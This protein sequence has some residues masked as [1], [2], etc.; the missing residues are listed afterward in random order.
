MSKVNHDPLFVDYEAEQ[1]GHL[2]VPTRLL[3][4]YVKKRFVF[5]HLMRRL[6]SHLIFMLAFFYYIYRGVDITE[7]YLA[8][9]GLREMILKLGATVNHSSVP[10]YYGRFEDTPRAALPLTFEGIHSKEAFWD[11]VTL[12][13]IPRLYVQS[14]PDYFESQTRNATSPTGT[15]PIHYR[16]L[17]ADYTL[18]WGVRF[19]QHWVDRPSN[20]NDCR[21]VKQPSDKLYHSEGGWLNEV[22][23]GKWRG[24]HATT[25][26]PGRLSSTLLAKQTFYEAGHEERHGD[27]YGA[28]SEGFDA[29][30]WII[31][32]PLDTK[33]AIALVTAMKDGEWIGSQTRSMFITFHAIHPASGKVIYTQLF[34]EATPG[35]SF[36]PNAIFRAS[37][38]FR[39]SEVLVYVAGII[40][41]LL[42]VDQVLHL[43]HELNRAELSNRIFQFLD[44]VTFGVSYYLF[45]DFW[46]IL[47][48]GFYERYMVTVLQQRDDYV[49]LYK[50]IQD[51]R[52][53]QEWFMALNMLGF[54]RAAR[55]LQLSDDIHLVWAT[56]KQS[57]SQVT[58]ILF[59]AIPTIIGFASSAYL[60]F[61]SFNVEFNTFP[62]AMM[63]LVRML[64]GDDEI[65]S[66]YFELASNAPQLTPFFFLCVL[67]M[68]YF[69][70]LSLLQGL[71]FSSWTMT[72]R[73]TH[74]RRSNRLLQMREHMPTHLGAPWKQILLWPFREMLYLFTRKSA[75]LSDY[76][77]MLD[78]MNLV[79]QKQKRDK[80]EFSTL[81]EVTEALITFQEQEAEKSK[82][83]NKE[84]A[85]N[86]DKVNARAKALGVHL[87]L[88]AKAAKLTFTTLQKDA[89]MGLK[90]AHARKEAQ[91]SMDLAAARH[92]GISVAYRFNREEDSKD[93]TL[94]D[95]RRYI[96]MREVN[97]EIR[98]MFHRQM[99]TTATMK[100]NLSRVGKVQ[101]ACKH[102]IA[103]IED[104]M[105]LIDKKHELAKAISKTL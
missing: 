49:D 18:I 85:G 81:K 33:E 93:D 34:F 63:A 11:W 5:H 67:F 4:R 53:V 82:K 102:Q 48:T 31:D 72:R 26:K 64:V 41:Q 80:K 43:L 37:N 89:Y 47:I 36:I 50:R 23:D 66:L 13:L 62:K 51:T 30:G 22:C 57:C 3:R 19:R 79:A 90:D 100:Q 73:L 29:N 69:L 2:F 70:L 71:I 54:V 21:F 25:G 58:N 55:F 75:V 91:D 52:G 96:M 86:A 15:T 87:I 77:W 78:A 105:E 1:I 32:L 88:S 60:S 59:F 24:V 27:T 38:F 103:H 68:Y 16:L 99:N 94:Q 44:V 104:R 40:A 6:F 74:Y 101:A 17:S 28:F 8:E 97:D 65:G 84:P 46:I 35:G 39:K 76:T 10:G 56:M 42:L 9:R 92:W 7:N 20:P 61:G 98:S 95:D 12:A 14:T 45:Y 83:K